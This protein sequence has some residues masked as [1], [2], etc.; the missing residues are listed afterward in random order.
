VTPSLTDT[1]SFVPGG[2]Q[3][4]G[5]TGELEIASL[6]RLA[7]VKCLRTGRDDFPRTFGTSI[8]FCGCVQPMGFTPL[9]RSILHSWLRLPSHISFSWKSRNAGSCHQWQQFPTLV[10]LVSESEKVV[11]RFTGGA[12]TTPIYSG[13]SWGE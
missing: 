11:L 12:Q 4:G 2:D 10:E 8:T 7:L 5:T 3:S 13:N 9:P 6:E 1:D